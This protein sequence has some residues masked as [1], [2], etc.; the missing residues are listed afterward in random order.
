[1]QD[2]ILLTNQGPNRVVDACGLV[3]LTG[4]SALAWYSRGTTWAP[5]LPGFFLLLG[6]VS[7]P[8][9][10]VFACFRHQPG[11]LTIGRR[12]RGAL[13]PGQAL[14]NRIICA[15]IRLLWRQ[16]VTDL[17]RIDTFAALNMLDTR[18]GRTVEMQVNAMQQGLVIIEVPVDTR[19][20]IGKSKIN[21]TLR[22][23]VGA[24]TGIL[25][26]I[27]KLRWQQYCQ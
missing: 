25:C 26:M 21:G 19:V 2:H 5:E 1:M 27:A 8:L 9:L 11:M 16:R 20:H 18:F 10:V 12:A 6:W 3:C 14:G 4:Y 23:A 22:G 7:L 24:S 15:L 13:S 17:A